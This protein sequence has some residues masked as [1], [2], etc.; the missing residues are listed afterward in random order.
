MATL[1]LSFT[2]KGHNDF[3][4]KPSTFSAISPYVSVY[5]LFS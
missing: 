1:T 5:L 2:H 3:G 4:S